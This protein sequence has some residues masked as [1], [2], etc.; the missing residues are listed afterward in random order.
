MASIDLRQGNY[1]RPAT[2]LPRLSPSASRLA[3]GPGKPD[4]RHELATI[5]LRQG[6]YAAARDQFAQ[7][8]TIR[9]Q[10]G[11]R[12]GEAATRHQLATIDLRQGNYAA[13]RDQFT[14]A[15]TIRQQLG[16]RYGEAATWYQLGVLA[17]ALGK[18]SEGLRL[19]ALCYLIDQAIGH[20]DTDS[21]WRALA[22][23]A[24]E[25][26][27]TQEQMET[28]LQQVAEAYEAD[29]GHG[30]LEAAFGHG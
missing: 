19:V 18:P 16:D 9:Q 12:A 22:E 8:L 20:A 21:A 17:K 30:L 25:L 24:S 14:Q 29:R 5:D 4:T 26:N 6:N 13:A 1:A 10:I 27:Y 15:L 2:S 23:M 28:L 7:A 11:H 3:I